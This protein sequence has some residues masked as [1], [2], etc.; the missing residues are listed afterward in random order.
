MKLVA[1]K[2]IM[3]FNFTLLSKSED[4]IAI[5]MY[6][7]PYSLVKD[8]ARWSNKKG[9]KMIMSAELADAIVASVFNQ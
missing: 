4:E 8:G 1:K 2:G 5:E 9:N 3:E 7:T 6:N